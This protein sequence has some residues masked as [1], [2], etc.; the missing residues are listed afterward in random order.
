MSG[1]MNPAE[2][3]NIRK[4]EK[5]FWWYR[6]M[7][8]ILFRMLEPL[9]AGRKIGRALEAGCGTGYLSRLLQVERGWPVVPLD[10]SWDGLRYAREMGVQQ[11]VQGDIRALPFPHGAFDLVMSIDVLAH[12]PRG[13]EQPAVRELSRVLAPGGLLVVRTAALDILRS[14]HSEFAH[15]RQRFT[16]RRLMELISGVRVR[17]LRCTYANSL[18][19]PAALARFRLW[20]PLMRAPISS[21]VQPVAPWLDR[22][23]YTPLALEAAWIGS[24]HGFPAG[25]S[26]IL[27]GEKM[28]A[29]KM[30]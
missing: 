27:V 16:R 20:E 3:A 15:E 7:R 12:L 25:Q 9:L 4:S 17:V 22:A 23:L 8:A 13:Q 30:L 10:L 26:L 19:L 28:K 14:R 18:L 24:G 11:P 5:D 21:G 6:G 2:F 1:F 29:E